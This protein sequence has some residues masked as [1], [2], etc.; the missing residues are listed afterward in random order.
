[1]LSGVLACVGKLGAEVAGH[2]TGLA[3]EGEIIVDDGLLLTATVRE[4]DRVSVG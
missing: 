2:S 1:M 3:S 4:D